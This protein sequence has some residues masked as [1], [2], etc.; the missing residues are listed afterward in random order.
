MSRKDAHDLNTCVGI[1]LGDFA[2]ATASAHPMGDPQ[3]QVGLIGPEIPPSLVLGE[4]AGEPNVIDLQA[5]PSLRGAGFAWPPNSRFSPS[6]GSARFP[7]AFAWPMLDHRDPPEWKWKA[8]E[9][10]ET[11]CAPTDAIVLAVKKALE[12]TTGSLGRPTVSLVVPNTLDHE[13]QDRLLRA[14]RLELRNVSLL[15]RPIAGALTWV[16]KYGPEILK[17]T[18]N[19]PSSGFT[20]VGTV[21]T[22]HMGLDAFE[23]TELELIPWEHD[24][25]EVLLPARRLPVL[26]SLYD[27]GISWAEQLAFGV[28]R[29]ADDPEGTAWNL[30]WT[31]GWLRQVLCPSKMKK[32]DLLVSE[33]FLG[34]H[35]ERA[36]DA[37]KDLARNLVGLISQEKSRSAESRCELTK[38]R[39]RFAPLDGPYAQDRLARRIAAA[40]FDEWLEEL[41]GMTKSNLPILG[42]IGTGGFADLDVEGE[43]WSKRMVR[44]ITEVPN[45]PRSMIDCSGEIL[46]RGAAFYASQCQSGLPSYLDALPE[47]Q[48]LVVREGEPTFENI[49]RLEDPYVVGGKEQVF[50]LS[51]LGLKVRQEENFLTLSVWREG[52]DSVREVR[53]EFPNQIRADTPVK[54]QI[55]I[56]AGQGNP[57]IEVIPD[58]RIAFGGRRVHLDWSRAHDTGRSREEELANVERTNPPLD[59]RLASYTSWRGGGTYQLPCA[60]SLIK[61]FLDELPRLRER[62]FENRIMNLI[63]VLRDKDPDYS[64][65]QIPDHATAVSSEGCLDGACLDSTLLTEFVSKLDDLLESGRFASAEDRIFRA[66][67][68]CS[69]DTPGLHSRLSSLLGNPRRIANH[70]LIAIGNCLRDPKEI[71]RFAKALHANFQSGTPRAPNDWMRALCRILQYREKAADEIPSTT[72]AA[73]SEKCLGY[74]EQQLDEG[75]ARYLY[76][77]AGLSIVY[78]LRRRRRDDSYMAPES[79]LAKRIKETLWRAI[80]QFNSG[81]LTAVAGFVN[82]PHVTELMIKYVDRKGKGR[83]VGLAPG[84]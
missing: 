83:L 50:E 53:V 32:L 65:H 46:C 73:I 22:V 26:P 70:H 1:A 81:Q 82:L 34:I 69:A 45:L 78:L 58:L 74:L 84:E 11:S 20:P 25:V 62:Q 2:V 9:R 52:H 63:A 38:S 7:L 66:L 49:L 6:K 10:R 54:L 29:D 41:R 39:Q 24:G 75:S 15:W 80:R 27:A 23:V 44:R 59:P 60:R 57:R 30:L 35:G 48:L 3:N 21:W 4:L 76:R 40:S 42:M 64:S 77:H 17:A 67:G 55:R 16:Q 37:G 61:G 51:G 33:S 8:S 47:L 28:C 13:S 71:V 19:R 12:S 18:R 14:L 56:T 72:C 36:V 43:P 68:Y 5:P 79:N 31:T